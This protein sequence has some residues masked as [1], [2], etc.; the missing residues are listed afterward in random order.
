M[1][2]RFCR[3]EDFA[4]SAE[5]SLMFHLISKNWI[6][7][8]N[9]RVTAQCSIDFGAVKKIEVVEGFPGS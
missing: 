9:L 4:I 3:F 5:S 6:N 2:A 7:E 8:F 1:S